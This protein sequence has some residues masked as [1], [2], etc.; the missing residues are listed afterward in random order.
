MS[1]TFPCKLPEYT[2]LVGTC[3]KTCDYM[4]ALMIPIRSC[5]V[6][7]GDPTIDGLNIPNPFIR[8]TPNISELNGR[9]YIK[10]D[11]KQYFLESINLFYTP[12]HG[13]VDATNLSSELQMFFKFN[14]E[15]VIISVPVQTGS[16]GIFVPF[17]RNIVDSIKK[18]EKSMDS[19][20]IPI[21]NLDT[22]SFNI[23]V[24]DFIPTSDDFYYY[25]PTVYNDKFGDDD[26]YNPITPPK[27][28][29][30][31]TSPIYIDSESMRYIREQ[32]TNTYTHH[33]INYNSIYFHEHNDN[34]ESAQSGALAGTI[35][36]GN[37]I[38]IDCGNTDY[39]DKTIGPQTNAKENTYYILLLVVLLLIFPITLFIS[40]YTYIICAGILFIF[41]SIYAIILN[42]G[43]IKAKQTTNSINIAMIFLSLVFII[44]YAFKGDDDDDD[45]V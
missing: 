31:Y 29:Y 39:D 20:S 17:F 28:V 42:T 15:Y 10:K 32:T 35:P 37:D 16:S 38:Y 25:E 13:F 36:L 30:V 8:I 41:S 5:N 27:A 7:K 1:V 43:K 34:S 12:M 44:F 33:S 18:L 22:S 19:Q 23:Q 6:I 26:S 40:K 2:S 9:A 4:K 21:D 45:D 24:Q 3:S 11:S 14:Q